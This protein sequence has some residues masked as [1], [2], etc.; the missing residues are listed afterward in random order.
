MNIG[1]RGSTNI[2]ELSKFIDK[3]EQNNV[4]MDVYT[5][6]PI[7]QIATI[8]KDS[9]SIVIDLTKSIQDQES[10]FQTFIDGLE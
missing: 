3:A 10:D 8:V 4:L 9:Q 2:S 5:F 6:D 1:V 7:N